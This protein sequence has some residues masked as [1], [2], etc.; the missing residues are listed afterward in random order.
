MF[1]QLLNSFHLRDSWLLNKDTFYMNLNFNKYLS[2]IYVNIF[3]IF[4]VSFNRGLS[5]FFKKL[6]DLNLKSSYGSDFISEIDIEN[7]KFKLWLMKNDNQA[8]SVYQPLHKKKISYETVMIKTMIAVIKHLEIK[9]FLDLGSFMGYYACFASKYFNKDLKV[10]AIESNE[11]YSNYIKKSLKENKLENVEVV[12]K[13]LSDK[14]EDLFVYKEGVYKSKKEVNNSV[15]TK[16]ITLDK[17]CLQNK[18]TPELIKI[19]VHGAEG[20]VLLGSKYILK[21]LVK[22]IL[23][24]LHTN[25]Y[26]NQFSDGLNRKKI[27][28]HLISLNFKCYLISS[29]R[30]FEK[31]IELRKKFN[32]NKKFEY[33]EIDMLNYNQLFFD[34]DQSDQFIFVCKSNIDIKSFGCF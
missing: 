7:T 28:E 6:N 19:D 27:I 11:Q 32:L 1:H 24:E 21:N 25:K 5:K 4:P 12:N 18:I 9:N 8:Q 14:E 23:L 17:V 31:S 13:I 33:I 3:K 30:N 15:S 22:V 10:Y 20:K 26:I 16:S 34:R 29:F 2:M